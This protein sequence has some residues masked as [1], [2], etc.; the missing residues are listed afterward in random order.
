MYLGNKS[1]K[2]YCKFKFKKNIYYAITIFSHQ[3]QNLNE[4]VLKNILTYTLL[5]SIFFIVM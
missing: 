4:F 5:G 3:K 1:G 2:K